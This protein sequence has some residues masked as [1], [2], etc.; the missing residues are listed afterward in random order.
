MFSKIQYNN[1]VSIFCY[2][3][4]TQITTYSLHSL[5]VLCVNVID[6]CV[7]VIDCCV[8]VIDVIDFTK[9]H[10]VI[11]VDTLKHVLIQFGEHFQALY[12]TY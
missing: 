1:I 5:F 12:L 11:H 2:F 6:C 8:K 3:L 10:V 7:K 9:R 4:K